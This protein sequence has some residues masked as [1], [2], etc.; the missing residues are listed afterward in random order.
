[1]NKPLNNVKIMTKSF[2][3]WEINTIF[4]LELVINTI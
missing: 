4:V 3:I 1:M 2:V